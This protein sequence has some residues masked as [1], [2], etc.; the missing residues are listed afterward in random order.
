MGQ[1]LG[2]FFFS[3]GADLM[4]WNAKNMYIVMDEREMPC[5]AF[6]RG[7]Q[8]LV[9]LPG[10]GDGLKN[11]QGMALPLAWM[12]RRLI[13][14]YRV[15]VLSRAIPL[16]ED[17][18]TADMAE[19]VAMALKKLGVEQAAVVGVSMGGMIAQ[20]LAARHPELVSKLVLTVT[21][22]CSNPVLE[23]SVSR[24]IDMAQRGDHRALMVDN[25]KRIYSDSYLKKYGWMFPVVA[26]FTKPRSYRQ[27]L[28]MAQACRTHD[29]R[30]VLSSIQT[31][32][33]VIGGE[34]DKTL[35]GD[36]SRA[37]AAAIP[38]AELKMYAQYGHG[39]YEEAVDFQS[40]LLDFLTK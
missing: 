20:H 32:T 12:Y 36:S 4:L 21:S 2:L 31:P 8:T 18:T 38:G 29:A 30:A 7:K 16:K 35:G 27:F 26:R 13:R 3:K 5:A 17:S 9:L 23:D 11:T 37:L 33:L 24:W 40:I 19:D 14:D 39:C 22:P 1:P 28:I 25:G 6:G 15:L 10:L 34:K